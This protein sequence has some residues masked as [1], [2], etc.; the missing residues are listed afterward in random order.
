RGRGRGRARWGR[1]LGAESD[2][3]QSVSTRAVRLYLVSKLG[4]C[5]PRGHRRRDAAQTGGSSLPAGGVD[6]GVEIGA[7]VV[8]WVQGEGIIAPAQ[9]VTLRPVERRVRELALR[10]HGEDVAAGAG[11]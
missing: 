2:S 9:A 3:A 6:G 10:H 4:G 7:C 5:D 1:P 8:A 11:K